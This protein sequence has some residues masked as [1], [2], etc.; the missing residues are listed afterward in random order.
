GIR[1]FNFALNQSVGGPQIDLSAPA[2]QVFDP[3][4]IGGAAP[5]PV[6]FQETSQPQDTFDASQEIGAGYGMLELPLVRD[7]LRLIAGV[8]TEYSYIK[9]HTVRPEAPTLTSVVRKENL[10]PLPVVNL[11]YSPRYDMNV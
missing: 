1:T 5:F 3:N 7:R 11:V 8:R 10:D 4:N 9:L 2:N 6:R